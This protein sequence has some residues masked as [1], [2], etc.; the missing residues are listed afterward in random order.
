MLFQEV[1]LTSETVI[2]TLEFIALIGFG[3]LAVI[4]YIAYGKLN[5][6]MLLY[7][8]LAFTVLF[9]SLIFQVVLP[10]VQT[11]LPED[12]LD[13][14]G[15]IIQFFAAFLFLAGLKLIKN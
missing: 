8:A 6:R 11:V 5:A 9:I 3:I 10:L 15:E 2:T 13:L 7:I 14:T 1:I 12:I 4:T